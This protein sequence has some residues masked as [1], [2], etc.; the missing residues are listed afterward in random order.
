[1]SPAYQVTPSMP[2][3]AIIFVLTLAMGLYAVGRYLRHDRRPVVVVFA[4]LMAAISSWELLNFFIDVTT[5]EQLKLLGKNA[6]NA[7]VFPVYAYGVLA[8]ALAYTGNWRWIRAVVVACAVQI[9]G[10]CAAVAL[11]PELLYESHGLVTQRPFIIGGFTVDQFVTLDRTLNPPF[12]LLWA[13]AQLLGLA[14]GAVLV[15]YVDRGP[16]IFVPGQIGALLIGV[17][18]PLGASF[19]LVTGIVSPAWNLVDVSFA[20]TTVVLA[21][22]VFRYRLFELVPMDSRQLAGIADEPVV[23][24]EN[25]WVVGSNS[26][27]R[28]AFGVGSGQREMAAETFFGPI[29]EQITNSHGPD[30]TDR[31]VCISEDD[32]D[33]CFKFN[34]VPIRTTARNADE[35]LVV[36]RDATGSPE[37][38][39]ARRRRNDRLEEFADIVADDLRND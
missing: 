33:R 4:V 23:L 16:R 29:A 20:V 39:R 36:F 22:A 32:G 5:S 38:N 34:Y 7:V 11:T 13:Q 6:V 24:L 15:L 10:M 2:V 19:L 26:A 18:A 21:L 35:R 1:M 30:G 31:E 12:F 9:I 37:S 27:A 28:T 3:Y 17:W 25:G 8:F 14:A